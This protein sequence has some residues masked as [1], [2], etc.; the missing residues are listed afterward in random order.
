MS[1]FTGC[2][3]ILLAL[4]LVVPGCTRAVKDV[5]V[6]G[7]SATAP[8]SRL[9]QDDS[10]PTIP[11]SLPSS[12]P[13]ASHPAPPRPGPTTPGRADAGTVRMSLL[14]E[15]EVALARVPSALSL[16]VKVKGRAVARR[17]RPPVDLALVI[18]RSGSMAGAN[19]P[20]VQQA[21]LALVAK[22]GD[23]DRVTLISYSGTVTRHV[24]RQPLND[25]GRALLR[26]K[27]LAMRADGSTALGPALVAALR[28]MER[29]RRRPGVLAH[30]MLL[31]DGRANV[32]ETR[33]RVLAER[34]AQ[35][36]GRG[37]SLSTLGVGLDFNDLL[38]ISLATQG[39][40]NYHFMERNDQ[41]SQ[42]LDAEARIL[43]TAVARSMV[44]RLSLAQGVTLH[45][46]Y[47][48]ATTRGR[49]GIRIRVGSLRAGQER[50]IVLRLGLPAT[51]HPKIVIGD[52]ALSY[53]DVERSGA[54]T[55][56]H[57]RL[58]MDT[59]PDARAVARS[60]RPDVVARVSE[61]EGA[62]DLNRATNA[63]DRG[64]IS[65]A[66]S[67]LD[68]AIGRLKQ[69]QRRTPRPRLKRMIRQLKDVRG[70]L[71]KVH[72]TPRGAPSRKRFLRRNRFSPYQS[73]QQ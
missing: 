73:Q 47:G 16:V 65:R 34:A 46:C 38:M 59:N 32:G 37:V 56:L 41:I 70:Q 30:V 11:W 51:H 9:T 61:V 25:R 14:P 52:F 8:P 69:Q 58:T 26:R 71:H 21:A 53:R 62:A 72:N 48:Y 66:R 31:S 44:L 28:L 6:E 19:L 64:S 20:R 42:V 63:I 55:R 1:R 5:A 45:H 15:T 40:G 12:P 23:G 36:F 49:E 57:Q 7:R 54:T 3:W 50:N 39:G 22:L 33:P 29:A 2:R 17:S 13:P 60:E 68:R 24:I 27:I 35:A 4:P 10:D 67:T 18:D 43:T